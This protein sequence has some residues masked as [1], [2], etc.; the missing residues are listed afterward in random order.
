MS[1]AWDEALRHLHGIEPLTPPREGG[2]YTTDE[3]TE[4]LTT[5]ALNGDRIA[6]FLLLHGACTRGGYS[7]EKI[8]HFRHY[9]SHENA[10]LLAFALPDQFRYVEGYAVTG[11]LVPV[12]H[13]WVIDADDRVIDT[14]WGNPWDATYCGVVIPH[15]IARDELLTE[16]PGAEI[17]SGLINFWEPPA[18]A[19]TGAA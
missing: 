1:E 16:G 9:L 13:A 3:L 8:D 11:T 18:A 12:R 2:S 14:T 19:G 15:V 17:L 6:G 4:A 5:M 10:Q 7:V